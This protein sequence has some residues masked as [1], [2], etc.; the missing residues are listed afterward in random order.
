MS[1][2]STIAYH[3]R[4]SIDEELIDDSTWVSLFAEMEVELS[5]DRRLVR[6]RF[7]CEPALLDKIAELH[8]AKM[9]PHQ[10]RE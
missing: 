10:R 4:W 3:L 2:K 1:T 6:L 5:I 8:A 9:F 7:K